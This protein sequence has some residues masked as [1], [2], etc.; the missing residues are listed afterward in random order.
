MSALAPQPG[1]LYE[2][3]IMQLH[4]RRLPAGVDDALSTVHGR[5]REWPIALVALVA[6]AGTWYPCGAHALTFTVTTTGDPGSSGTMSLRQAVSAANLSSDSLVNFAPGLVD[7]TITLT[8]GEIFITEPMT[9]SG[10]GA[11]RLTISGSG[12]SRIFNIDSLASNPSVS[13]NGVTLTNGN[14]GSSSGGAIMS[15]I[16]T[17]SLSQSRVTASKA[18]RGGAIYVAGGRVTLDRAMI[19]GNQA[20][21]FGGGLFVKTGTN[22][23]IG[24]STISNNMAGEQG[25]GISVASTQE[26]R[27]EQSTISGNI[28]PQPS[29]P[30][31][32]PHGGGGLA[33]SGIS[34][35]AAIFNSTI[36]QNY[37]DT[38]G[39][40]AGVDAY[41]SNVTGFYWST[42]AGNSAQV[43]ETGIGISSAG[44][45]PK[46]VA[47]IV[48]NNFSQ[49][50]Q[51]DLFGSFATSFSLIGNAGSATVSG[52]GNLIGVD[53]QLGLLKDNG[54]PTLTLLPASTSPV[55]N[56]V[57]CGCPLS[58]QRG[59]PRAFAHA[60]GD[61]GAVERQYPE[62]LIF[63]NGFNPP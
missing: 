7:S 47:T 17:L 24:Y 19:S 3:L 51:D 1:A 29:G 14:A 31:E 23:T 61:M 5:A 18:L 8:G 45:Q 62:D 52:A 42:I 39:A 4:P 12:S 6:A 43:D 41:S 46:I 37:A 40:G 57:P 11:S 54:G 27:I 58:D 32:G 49:T 16:A 2:G 10:P 20:A 25:G 22:V 26:V 60:N 28:V 34:G 48:A 59:S 38:G 44:N 13:I 55:I 50:S 33:L 56:K 53:P 36:T 15:F 21:K 30:G 9:I 35:Y 63:R